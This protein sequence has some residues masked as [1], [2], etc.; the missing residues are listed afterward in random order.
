MEKSLISTRSFATRGPAVVPSWPAD[1]GCGDGI[2][3]GWIDRTSICSFIRFWSNSIWI[4]KIEM[5]ACSDWWNWFVW[6]LLTGWVT[7]L[8]VR[9][10]AQMS[11]GSSMHYELGDSFLAHWVVQFAVPFEFRVYNGF[12]RHPLIQFW[13]RRV[14][15][16]GAKAGTPSRKAWLKRVPTFAWQVW[17]LD[18]DCGI[19]SSLVPNQVSYSLTYNKSIRYKWG[20]M[21]ALTLEKGH[22]ETHSKSEKPGTPKFPDTSRASL[23]SIK[24]YQVSSISISF[25]GVWHV[26]SQCLVFRDCLSTQPHDVEAHPQS[27]SVLGGP[28]LS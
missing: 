5:L 27:V 3:E 19:H 22:S 7:A 9:F 10:Y 14:A 26:F 11:N 21:V 16:L 20:G 25:F 2:L 8:P 6:L 15:K 24:H 4:N 12:A 13:D 1:G 17:A 23:R 28:G 18:Y